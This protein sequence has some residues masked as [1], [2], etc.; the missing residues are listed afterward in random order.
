MNNIYLR[1]DSSF[2]SELRELDPNNAI[3]IFL[4]SRFG[5]LFLSFQII[6]ANL[7][8]GFP[9]EAFFKRIY[10]VISNKEKFYLHTIF[11]P[12]LAQQDAMIATFMQANT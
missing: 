5:Y 1:T 11:F 4:V 10:S 12:P 6:L 7:L 8:D 9:D 2:L 3:T